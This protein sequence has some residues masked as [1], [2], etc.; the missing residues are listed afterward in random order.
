MILL[1]ATFPMAALEFKV[2]EDLDSLDSP[3][4]REE[5]WYTDMIPTCQRLIDG[6]NIKEIN[7][8]GSSSSYINGLIE[9]LKEIFTIPIFIL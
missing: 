6:Y 7:F 2:I 5:V 8:I 4:I 3:L 9:Q 1:I